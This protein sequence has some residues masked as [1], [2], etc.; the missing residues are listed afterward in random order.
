MIRFASRV[1]RRLPA[2]YILA[3]PAIGSA[4]VASGIGEGLARL[5]QEAPFHI[6]SGSLESALLQFSRQAEIQVIISVQVSEISVAAVDGRSSARAVL[7]TLL[8]GTGLAYTLV[9][10]TITIRR[11][12]NP[13]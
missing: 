8:S 11:P 7:S 3:L 2:V 1:L 6:S 5:E 12:P 13:M 9:G 4:Q 10:N